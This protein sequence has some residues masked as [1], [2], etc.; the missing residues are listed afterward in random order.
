LSASVTLAG[1]IA[2]DVRTPV[3]VME[4]ASEV[5]VPE[6]ALIEIAVALA[7]STVARPELLMLA[8]VG[9]EEVQ[10]TEE[11]MLAVVPSV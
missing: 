1:V 5:I 6:T 9:L 11:V 7:A 4:L 3:I 2:I 10:V 8:A